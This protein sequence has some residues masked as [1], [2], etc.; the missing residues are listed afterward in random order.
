MIKLLLL[1]ADWLVS[2]KIYSFGGKISLTLLQSA[3]PLRLVN[4]F[5]KLRR[6]LHRPLT[7]FF[8]GLVGGTRT[9]TQGEGGEK[10]QTNFKKEEKKKTSKENLGTCLVPPHPAPSK[11]QK[12]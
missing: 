6:V 8:P 5:L 3:W 10:M 2:L 11:A 1:A 4:V 12:Q 7:L 9:S